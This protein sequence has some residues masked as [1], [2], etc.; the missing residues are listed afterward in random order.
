MNSDRHLG[1]APLVRARAQPVPD[2]LLKPADRD[3]GSRPCRVTRHPLPS[4]AAVLGDV[5]EMAVPL[6]GRGLGCVA[7]HRGRAWRDNDRRLGV[8]LGHNGVNTVLVVTAIAGE[9]GHRARDL[10]ELLTLNDYP[11]FDGYQDYIKDE[12]MSHA[13]IEL[14]LYKKRKKIEAMGIEYDEEALASGEYDEV[15]VDYEGGDA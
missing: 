4:H 13:R 9:R 15:L 2:H 7:R 10:V 1:R 6:R 12:A 3:L 14:G 8:A 11:V 5:L